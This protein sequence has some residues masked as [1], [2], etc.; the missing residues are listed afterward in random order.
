MNNP[1]RENE[2]WRVVASGVS[3]PIFTSERLN[4]FEAMELL[5]KIRA[6]GVWLK[7]RPFGMMFPKP[8]DGTVGM[9]FD[10]L[11]TKAETDGDLVNV[12]PIAIFVEAVDE[13]GKP[14]RPKLHAED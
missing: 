1:K 14:I 5:K 10:D 12:M 2:T 6:E 7:A 3:G 4:I 11:A 13:D 9:S 8:T